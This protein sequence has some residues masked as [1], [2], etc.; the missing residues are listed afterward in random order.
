MLNDEESAPVGEAGQSEG[1]LEGVEV[2]EAT[3]RTRS[4]ADQ[5]ATLVK[6]D[7]DAAAGLVRQWI[8]QDH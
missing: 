2:D 8:I 4:I 1:V 7:P 5:V 6:E 3:V